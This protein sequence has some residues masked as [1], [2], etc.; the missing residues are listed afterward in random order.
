MNDNPHTPEFGVVLTDNRQGKVAI[1]LNGEFLTN[2][3][4]GQELTRP[5]LWP[6]IGPGGK[7][8]TRDFPL[9][10]SAIE[11]A[12]QYDDHP[13]HKSIWTAWGDLNGADFWSDDP[14]AGRQVTNQIVVESGYACGLLHTEETWVDRDSKPIVLVHKDIIFH[15]TPIQNRIIDYHVS[16]KA[17]FG[18]VKVGDTKEG[19]F[20]AMRMA[21]PL[22][23]IHGATLS[24]SG[25]RRGE[26]DCWG[27]QSPWCD[28]SGNVEGVVCGI[29]LMDSPRNQTYPTRWH[30]RDYG[31][32]TANPFGLTHFL[33]DQG[34]RGDRML[35]LG[36]RMD[37][38]YRII[39]HAGDA[40]QA[41][42]DRQYEAFTLLTNGG[43][44]HQEP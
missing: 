9:A 37:F 12:Q 34:L 42:I 25:G 40:V 41:E 26:P 35:D 2:Y 1:T 4:Y 3:L 36:Q 31:L 22:A 38:E 33:P 43:Y 39:L 44:A 23:G 16:F 28:C 6:V 11:R 18:M 20:V 17:P 32:I 14:Q 21:M 5:C 30:A 10:D 7:H 13:H 24:L 15:N 29:T 8:L 19:G 27:L